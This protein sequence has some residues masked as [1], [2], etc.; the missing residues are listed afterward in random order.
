MSTTG[1]SDNARAS[2]PEADQPALTIWALRIDLSAKHSLKLFA[3][4]WRENPFRKHP[5]PSSPASKVVIM[6]EAGG[7]EESPWAK[8]EAAFT[9]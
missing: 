1:I 5:I 3:E 7:T 4:L 9:R 6:A 2:W 8:G